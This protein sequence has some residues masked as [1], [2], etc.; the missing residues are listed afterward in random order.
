[1][2]KLN[3]HHIDEN[4]IELSL[5]MVMFVLTF[6][7]IYILPIGILYNSYCDVIKEKTI[8]TTNI[9]MVK[10]VTFIS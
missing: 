10:Y 1:M 4:Y 9:I 3:Y 8:C 6:H 5:E 2:I 7:K